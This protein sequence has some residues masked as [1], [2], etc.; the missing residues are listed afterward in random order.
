MARHRR[1]LVVLAFLAAA[2]GSESSAPGG[3]LT[4]IT[5][6]AP[7]T[8]IARNIVG[9]LVSLD[10]V[11]PPGVD[12]HTFEPTPQTAKTLRG[13]D[14]VF[15]N[16]L[17]LEESTRKLAEANRSPQGE[18]VL[19][20][21]LTIGPDQYVY[22]S[23]FPKEHGDPN[24]HLW[25]NPRH[26]ES[27]ARIIAEKVAERDPANRARYEA[28]LAAFSARIDALDRA[29]STSTATIPEKHRKLVTYH[30]S[31]AYFAP[32]YG[33]SVLA[34]VQPADFSEPSPQEVARIIEQVRSE[35]VPAIFGSEVFPS[36][37]LEQVARETG[38]RYVDRLRDDELPDEPGTARHSYFGMIVEDVSVIT[39]A[40][41]GDP[42]T[43]A[44]LD[45]SNVA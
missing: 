14:L 10:G 30:D 12:S 41:G 21:D 36:P 13:A 11:I 26:A 31:F 44:Y 19:L 27:Y 23:S 42:S 25:M 8:N 4:V 35:G 1:L 9:D 40:L 34:A 43:L 6:V 3:R 45:V 32:R 15:L 7:L 38:A 18:I 17:Q 33:L 37:V 28:N 5:S 29:I 2:C 39:E 20:G 22:D 16:G 24:P